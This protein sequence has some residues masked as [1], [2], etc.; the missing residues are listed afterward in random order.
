MPIEPQAQQMY[1]VLR[2]LKGV[3]GALCFELG[4]SHMHRQCH[5]TKYRD[6]QNY[7]APNIE[8]CVGVYD[9]RL[10]HMG[11]TRSGEIL[12]EPNRLR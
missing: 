7:L 3:F 6:C 12:Q 11:G 2:Q 10:M 5:M 9:W 4:R 1:S 8:Q